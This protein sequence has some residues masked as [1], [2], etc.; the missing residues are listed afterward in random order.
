M[1]KAETGYS[2]GEYVNEVRIKYTVEAELHGIRHAD[3]ANEIGF[4]SHSA[5]CQWL[6][7][8]KNKISE[9]KQQK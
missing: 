6:N 7:R 1:F 2:I 3:I 4:S 9:L 5:F 8:H